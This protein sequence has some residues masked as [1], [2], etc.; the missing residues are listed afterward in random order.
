MLHKWHDGERSKAAVG[1]LASKGPLRTAVH[2]RLSW[3]AESEPSLDKC[4]Q[5]RKYQSGETAQTCRTARRRGGMARR[6]CM[7]GEKSAKERRQR[8]GAI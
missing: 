3:A 8:R 6:R 5:G 4:R 1:I 7:K 2:V